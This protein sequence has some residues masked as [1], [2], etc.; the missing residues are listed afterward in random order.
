MTT[1]EDALDRARVA[2]GRHSW[3]EAFDLLAPNANL[4]TDG[5]ELLAESAWWTGRLQECIDAR[6]LAFSQRSESGDARGAAAIA[7]L[8]AKDHFVKGAGSIGLAWMGRAERLLENEEPCIELGQLR[9]LQA[10][11]AFEAHRDFDSAL[12][13]A[14]ETVEL[15]ERF[16]DRDLVALGLHDQ[17]RIFVASGRVEEGMR[18]IDEVTVGAMSGELGPMTTGIVYCNTITI[19]EDLAD[20]R[21]ASDWTDA[22][23]R[24]CDRMAIAG[25][26][27]M[28]RVHRAGVMRRSGRWS[29][30][31]REAR[32]A[33]DE[34]RSWNVE[35][36]AQAMYEVGELRLLQGD[37]AG[38]EVAFRE[39]HEMGREPQPGLAWLRLLQ[40]NTDAA[41]ASIA[42]AVDEESRELP[43][44]RL[45]PTHVEITLA[46]GDVATARAAAEELQQLA[47][48]YGTSALN[49]AA[50]SSRGLVLLAEGDAAEAAKVLRRARTTWAELQVPWEE[51][52]TRL[53]L[54]QAYAAMG[55]EDGRLLELRTARATF[56]RL[57]AVLDLRR[58]NELFGAQASEDDRARII[59][60]LMFTDVVGS[61]DL[62][63]LL[64]DEAWGELLR[65]HDETMR[66][67]F[68]EHGGE[69]VKHTGDGFFVAFDDVVPAIDCA[70]AIQQRL[71]DHRRRHGFAPDVRIGIHA[72]E[73]TRTGLDYKGMGVHEAARIGAVAARGEIVVSTQT[74]EGRTIRWPTGDARIV[75]LKGVAT[76]VEVCPVAWR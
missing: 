33:Y 55:D 7:L 64:G 6:Q 2:I 31:E 72:A 4:P 65:W 10:V 32:H 9:R 56:A 26:P 22:A 48:A 50:A 51:A 27:G 38:A 69:E 74:L 66:A 43:R 28:C 21:R 1:A 3:R 20:F 62:A 63:G 36:A 71:V 41:M 15:G 35:Y 68:V 49:A 17:G 60:T 24:W 76:P 57:G 53:A 75:D 12:E 54:A 18:L 42:R 59:R 45:L 11:V 40:G 67:L 25:F 39:A 29:D 58:A 37:L 52:R 30:A 73:V 8:L 61:T 23:K 47:E 70:V 13:R 16:G 46:A 14:R 5:L 19:C 34:L 44:A